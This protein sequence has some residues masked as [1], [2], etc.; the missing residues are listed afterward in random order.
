MVAVLR[1]LAHSVFRLRGFVRRHVALLASDAQ[2]LRILEIGSGKKLRGRDHYSVRE[3]FHPSNT[4]V[5]SDVNPAF[6]HRVIDVT[7]MDIDEEFDLILCL[8]V[9]EHVYDVQAAVARLHRALTPGGRLVVMVPGYYPL[10]DEPHDYWRFTEH[11]L[12]RML[13]HFRST[14]VVVHGP[15]RYPLGYWVE[16]I[17]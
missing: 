14:A 12:R 3:M 7:T 2:D 15:R 11:S 10:H 4:F 13:G 17:R 1:A 5:Q 6:G 8:N 9:L 16:A